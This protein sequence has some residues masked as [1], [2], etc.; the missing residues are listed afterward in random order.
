[1][2]FGHTACTD[3]RRKTEIRAELR[4]LIVTEEGYEPGFFRQHLRRESESVQPWA[5]QFIV[6]KHAV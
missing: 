2:I 5:A 3:D 4:V 6:L 1:M